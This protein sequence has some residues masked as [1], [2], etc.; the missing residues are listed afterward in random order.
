MNSTSKH[1]LHC[2][3]LFAVVLFFEIFAGGIKINENSFV[4]IDPW[5]EYGTTITIILYLLRILTFLTL[6]QVLF[7]FCGLVFYNAFPEKVTL[8]GEQKI[9]N[10]KKFRIKTFYC[11]KSLAGTIYMH[12]C[13]NTR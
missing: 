10:K 6:P 9:C 3:L 11:R 8:K 5:A 12:S 4:V 13:C 1:L 7:N 2:F